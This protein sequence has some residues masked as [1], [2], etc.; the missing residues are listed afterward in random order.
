M[1]KI[2]INRKSELA[3]SILQ[4]Y[5]KLDGELRAYLKPYGITLQQYNVLK[6]LRGAKQPLTTSVIR[7][8]MI[9]PMADTS[10]LVD[11]LTTKGL[12]QRNTCCGDKRLVDVTISEQGKT[13]LERMTGMDDVLNK[14]FASLEFDETKRLNSLLDKLRG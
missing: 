6:I 5:Q 12:V 8:R 14:V 4:A 11:R 13:F 3:I 2:K 1:K 9:E 7:E 10:R